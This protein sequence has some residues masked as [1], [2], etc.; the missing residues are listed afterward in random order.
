MD[1][2][3]DRRVKVRRRARARAPLLRFFDEWAQRWV[4]RV[5]R[6][7][8]QRLDRR[9]RHRGAQGGEP[10]MFDLFLLDEGFDNGVQ[11]EQE[12]G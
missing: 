5:I 7:A 6:C 8:Q 12:Q 11:L 10:E 3:L 2:E 9:L 4:D 1:E